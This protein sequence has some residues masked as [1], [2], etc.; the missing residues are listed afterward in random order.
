M[1]NFHS[2]NRVSEAIP[3]LLDTLWVFSS[4]FSIVA[5]LR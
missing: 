4:F 1:I 5:E 3:N 2:E